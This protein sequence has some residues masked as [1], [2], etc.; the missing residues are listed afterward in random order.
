M[1]P[2]PLGSKELEEML[3]GGH[4]DVEAD[5]EEEAEEG[6]RHLGEKEDEEDGFSELFGSTPEPE[7][8]SDV[9][10]TGSSEFQA[11]TYQYS[12]AS[13]I[14]YAPEKVVEEGVK[15][16][17]AIK[18]RLRK[19]DL[20]G[21]WREEVWKQEVK[22]LTSWTPP[23][24]VIAVC[25][26]TGAGK[27]S[28]INAVLDDNIVPTSSIRA[29]TSVVTEIRY[30]NFANK[31][32]IA[33][34][35][36]FMTLEEWREELD[37][38]LQDLAGDIGARRP[39]RVA[40]LS[41]EA[42]IA[43]AKV[44][45][46]YPTISLDQLMRMKVDEIL[47]LDPEVLEALGK[48]K[49]ITAKNS[50]IFGRKIA[51]Y[52]GS[53]GSAIHPDFSTEDSDIDEDLSDEN[54][55]DS[56]SE[57]LSDE[58]DQESEGAT[59]WPL[60]RQ[61]GIKCK[62][63]ALSTGAIL[64]D[65]PG[66]AD[67]NAARNNIAKEYMK[68]ANF[69]WIL[70]DINRA[71]SDGTAQDLLGDA[72]KYQLMMD[73]N[74][75]EKSITFIASKC[76]ELQ[77][78]EVI[79]ELNLHTNAELQAIQRQIDKCKKQADK[80]KSTKYKLHKSIDSL[81]KRLRK[82]E[83]DQRT[84]KKQYDSL[85]EKLRRSREEQMK[86]YDQI[87]V[88]GEQLDL[89]N[90][91][92][93]AFCS[94]K[95]SEH[96]RTILQQQFRQGLR[97]QDEIAAEQGD[98]QN[99]DPNDDSDT[100]DY[101]AI[102]LNVFAC[103][104]RDYMALKGLIDGHAE[105]SCFTDVEQTGVPALQERCSELTTGSRHRA[106]QEFLN[107]L[108]AFVGTVKTYIEHLDSVE[109]CVADLKK[110]FKD[111]LKERCR[112]G[113]AARKATKKAVPTVEKFMNAG[114]WKK[115][116]AA[117]RR[118][119]IRND[120]V[121]LN[122]RLLKP[123][124]KSIARAWNKLFKSDLLGGFEASIRNK[125]SKLLHEIEV[126]APEELRGRA[127][128]QVIAC[129]ET[130]N[131]SMREMIT[132]MESTVNSRQ[133]TISYSM[134]PYLREEL[135]DAYMETLKITGAGSV[136][137]QK[138]FFRCYVY[139]NIG[140]ILTKGNTRILAQLDEIASNVGKA[141]RSRVGFSLA[142]AIEVNLAVL[143]EEAY[144][145]P[146]Q[147]N[148]RAPHLLPV[149][150]P[151]I[152]R[153]PADPEPN[154]IWPSDTGRK[155]KSGSARHVETPDLD[156]IDVDDPPVHYAP[157]SDIRV[158]GTF[159]PPAKA[160]YKRYNNAKE[161]EYE[162]EE[163]LRE[164]MKMVN[165]LEE[166]LVK[167]SIN[168]LRREVWEREIQSLKEETLPTTLIALSLATGAGKSSVINAVLD[169]NIVPTSG[170]R[171]CT[172]VVTRI[173]YREDPDKITAA[174]AFLTREEWKDELTALLQD[175]ADDAATTDTNSEAAIA[176][177][178]CH[179]E[180]L[181]TGAIIVDLPGVAD[182][183]SA[184]NEIAKAYMGQAD[185]FWI[186]APITRAVSD[187]IAMVTSTKQSSHRPGQGAADKRCRVESNYKA[188]AANRSAPSHSNQSGD[189]GAAL[190]YFDIEIEAQRKKLNT[191]K[192][193]RHELVDKM[194]TMQQDRDLAQQEKVAFC[195]LKRSE[196]SRRIIQ[197]DFR[198]GL[199]EIDGGL[200]LFQLEVTHLLNIRPDRNTERGD[201][202]H[203]DSSA[204]PRDYST[205]TLPVFTC[206]SRDYLRLTG[207][208]QGDGAA[209]CFTDI[210]DTGVPALRAWCHSLT[211][212]RAS[213]SKQFLS[214]ISLFSNQ[215]RTYLES[216]TGEASAISRKALRKQWE[217]PSTRSAQRKVSG[218]AEKPSPP[219]VYESRKLGRNPAN[220]DFDNKERKPAGERKRH[221]KKDGTVRGKR[222][223]A[224]RNYVESSDSEMD[225]RNIIE[226]LTLDEFGEP[227]GIASRLRKEFSMLVDSCVTDLKQRFRDN[228]EEE[229][230]IGAECASTM[231]VSAAK[232][233]TEDCG[234]RW[235]TYR[236]VLARKGSFREHDLNLKLLHAFTLTIRHS[237]SDLFQSDFFCDLKN[238]VTA[239]ITRLLRDFQNTVAGDFKDDA[240]EQADLCLKDAQLTLEA[241]VDVVNNALTKH[242]K[243]ISRCMVPHVQK[244]MWETYI[245]AMEH[246]G[247]HS[248]VRQKLCIENF[249]NV[250]DNREAMF[251]N[252]ADIIMD[253][254]DQAAVA[255]G[256]ALYQ[257][258]GTNLAEKIE[259]H[260]S[261]LWEFAPSDPAQARARS[262]MTEV[263]DGVLTQVELWL[264]AASLKY[265]NSCQNQPDIEMSEA[266]EDSDDFYMSE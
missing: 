247:T 96:S 38:L 183:N 14:K 69:F 255:V 219:R 172:S 62:A 57:R 119:G 71:V 111:S 21:R 86:A 144:D 167:L 2:A 41:S 11:P 64:V 155:Q 40:D 29:C 259:V 179:A 48:T 94:I 166:S 222:K 174:I 204:L 77:C 36:S 130:V 58:S 262:S 184:R 75:D 145:D 39:M 151:R 114:H 4:S 266:A 207:K 68:K 1:S 137:E 198:T 202:E 161:I 54:S 13:D 156:L 135:K 215:I 248:Y 225:F 180:A 133:Q 230:Q 150:W 127:K 238:S 244:V 187:K 34:D 37:V 61:V 192:E 206:S 20:G 252:G 126:S 158:T 66:V 153:E 115:F 240:R 175:L 12:N 8:D 141:L 256:K 261:A 264:E 211:S 170:I 185:C 232:K 186:V 249:L 214:R 182:A 122:R 196:Y 258:I 49:R 243:A 253:H 51:P 154:F 149:M 136:D 70:A 221:G 112:V 95:R 83:Q 15:M 236:A 257:S 102:N 163:A 121:N 181:K 218:N 88:L 118:Q 125:I 235:N 208:V 162:P 30:H 169:D 246:R 16:V 209:S 18:K 217:S 110:R 120:G 67:L 263:V 224:K 50:K 159:Q 210:S 31:H 7:E 84:T 93:K 178:K 237:W 177:Q 117:L 42:A 239:A 92:K 33:A 108:S 189:I 200:I 52:I 74:Y 81:H 87:L 101:E 10:T 80:Y 199:R 63:K 89:L 35:V 103:S 53:G 22:S 76:D 190:P 231:A 60:I 90:K 72:F 19:L 85:N 229:C 228:L 220:L 131:A 123:F 5:E 168:K 140:R 98:Q 104:S 245:E 91:K 216:I 106:A 82:L 147:L 132:H 233:F 203:F 201:S 205:I 100:K 129:F 265:E 27:S 3:F 146:V 113:A 55:N 25:G 56:D 59:F 260:L 241:S 234:M 6:A 17:K 139:S 152:K 157:D 109:E 142:Q 165:T 79:N 32:H 124:T 250:D 65:L 194:F 195:S 107:R 148:A 78:H 26:A 138:N 46:V 226:G 171:A 116:R 188:A 44:H 160:T 28:I 193:R 223:S 173:S 23:D 105:P 45:A 254:L 24:T 176:W 43:Y 99:Y 213:T 251:E 197:E 227:I 128:E 242:Q 47:A 191:A 9:G 164:G 212:S 134:E 73:G 143:W 97:M